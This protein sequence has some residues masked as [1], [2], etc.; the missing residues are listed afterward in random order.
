MSGKSNN[1]TKVKF[2]KVS[3]VGETEIGN[4]VNNGHKR[5][6]AVRLTAAS[7]PECRSVHGC[8]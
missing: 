4:K 6:T 8:V 3:L 2:K 5:T 7:T 1:R